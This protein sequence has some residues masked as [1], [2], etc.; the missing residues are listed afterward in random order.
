MQFICCHV[1]YHTLN[2]RNGL[3]TASSKHLINKKIKLTLLSSGGTC[4]SHILSIAVGKQKVCEHINSNF[5]SINKTI[6]AQ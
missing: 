5:K 2:R 1:D 6:H 4:S 3:L